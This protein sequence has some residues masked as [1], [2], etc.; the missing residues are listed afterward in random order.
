[1][2]WYV[3]LSFLKL[4]PP[5]WEA[6]NVFPCIDAKDYEKALVLHMLMKLT[7]N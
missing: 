2:T 3:V 7:E 6:L 4:L 1:M 5:M